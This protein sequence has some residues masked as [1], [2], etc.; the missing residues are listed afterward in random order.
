MRANIFEKGFP[1]LSYMA[2]RWPKS[3]Y[4][5][6][7]YIISN[8][9][10]PDLCLLSKSCLKDLNFRKKIPLLGS[11]K[12]LSK[13]CSKNFN[14]NNYHNPHHFK[15]V[16]IISCLFAKFNSLK[17]N[18]KIILV[19]I[20]L[21]HDMNHQGRRI[22]GKP[23]YQEKKTI[24][25]LERIIYGKILN[26][27]IW[28]NIERILLNTYFPAIPSSERDLTEKIILKSDVMG[29][30]IFGDESGMIFSER[31]KQELSISEKTDTFFQKFKKTVQSRFQISD[32]LKFY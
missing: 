10:K 16:L 19:I 6:K 17:D 11:L 13:I 7:K 1:S 3:K 18:E 12:Y 28:K 20:A 4:T 14:Y 24:K 30:L 9:K 21:T 23:Y 15:V 31:L 2:I 32:N 27:K 22:I 25:D 29:S 8:Y 26:H 5:L